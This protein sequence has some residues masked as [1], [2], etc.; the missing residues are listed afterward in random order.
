VYFV[1]HSGQKLPEYRN[2]DQIFTFIGGSCAHTPVPIQSKFGKRQQTH[3]LHLHA[4][5]HLNLFAV[6]PFRDKKQFWANLTLGAPI[7]SPL[8][9]KAEIDVLE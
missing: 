8:S 6:L 3:G 9:M 5:F 4:K 1:A 2:F 7:P